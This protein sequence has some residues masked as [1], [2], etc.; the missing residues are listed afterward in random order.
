MMPAAEVS[1]IIPTYN[2]RAMVREAI[3][4]VLAQSVACFELI[5][6]DD[7]S[8]DGT[9]EDLNRIAADD[10][11]N[12]IRIDTSAHRGPAAA[13]NCGVEAAHAP[14][15]AFL[16]SDDLWSPLKL[17]RQL[18][19]M[20]DHPE[21]AI[22]QT[23]EIW[24]RS[25]Q[26]VN[27]GRRH[28]KRAGDIFADSLRICLISPSAVMMRADL[29]RSMGGFDESMAACEDYDLWLRILADHEAG[30]IDEPL[31]TRR[32]GHPDQ[33][34]A[35]TPALD[36]FRILALA[37]LLAQGRLSIDRRAAV[38]DVLA[39]KCRIY[40]KGLARRSR[41]E[42]AA[43]FEDLA[44]RAQSTR[45][46]ADDDSIDRTVNE[47]RHRITAFSLGASDWNQSRIQGVPPSPSGE[48]GQGD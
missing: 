7:G 20:S 21:C 38:A 9:L 29:F 28:R 11:G 10:R 44:R 37:K 23:G 27:P 22:S 47:I 19:F 31:V 18:A 45:R 40:A 24:M 2:R 25:G 43:F 42:D 6:I 39:E 26:R 12:R 5:V 34:S 3:A 8:T 36:R 15:I 48:G 32:A 17:E 14:L 30:L 33:L 16:D 1:V 46:E 41:A 13:R 4:S 35:A